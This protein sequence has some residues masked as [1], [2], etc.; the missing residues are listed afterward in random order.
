MSRL[1]RA[2]QYIREIKQ[3]IVNDELVSP[4][5]VPLHIR[6]RMVP[7]GFLGRSYIMYN[8]AENDHREYLSDVA[9]RR[10]L[11]IHKGN[12]RAAY[13]S[14]L[15]NKLI[16]DAM[17][18][19]LARVPTVHAYVSEGVIHCRESWQQHEGRAP[20]AICRRVKTPVVFKPVDG[21]K[22]R[23]ILIVRAEDD[24]I[25]VN[26]ESIEDTA[27]DERISR[28]DDYFACEFIKQNDHAAGLYPHSTNTIRALT[29]LDPETHEPF[30][31]AAVQR[32]GTDKSA[33]VD[34]FVRGGLSAN[35]DLETG[36]LSRAA[37]AL[38]TR[39]M[40]WHDMHPD[41]GAPITG[42]VTPCWKR[43]HDGVL[44]VAGALP[45]LK[46]VAWDVAQTDDGF[47]LIEANGTADIGLIQIHKPLLR[48][49]RA[50]RFYKHYG[51]I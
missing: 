7:R 44:E 13:Q 20:S 24:R 28:L 23:G 33:P 40:N 1:L 3:F 32:I 29:M 16:F 17:L 48:D 10:T 42:A 9:R 38:A 45:F 37:G 2:Y 26:G 43:I 36:E 15:N 30:M 41:T 25:G 50:R 6:L 18:Q 14:V 4:I 21:R 35:I 34:N 49:P 12:G 11:R 27:F 39:S 22:G 5:H 46:T 8:F 19:P 51:I 47:A 31:A